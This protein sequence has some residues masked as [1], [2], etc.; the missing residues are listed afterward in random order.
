[1]VAGGGAACNSEVA[2]TATIHSRITDNI[3]RVGL[4]YQFHRSDYGFAKA[5]ATSRHWLL[6]P[7]EKKLDVCFWH[8]AD[9]IAVL[10][11]VRFWG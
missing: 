3:V 6:S 2:G 7:A 9:I 8:K 11:D 4:N 5:P 10:N 1:V